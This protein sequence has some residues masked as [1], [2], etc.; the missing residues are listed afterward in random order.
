MNRAGSRP[1]ELL[2]PVASL[3]ALGAAL[4]AELGA[5][6]AALAMRRAGYAAGEALGG[7]LSA[8]IAGRGADGA[9]A[10]DQ[11]GD[12]PSDVFWRRLADF[13]SGRNWGRLRFRQ[14]HEGLGVLEAEKWFEADASGDA[15]RPSCHFTTGMLAN[16]LGQVSGAEIA[17]L[18][19]TCRS[20]GAEQCSFLFGAPPTLQAVYGDLTAGRDL[21]QALLELV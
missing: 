21:Q 13:F 3:K 15:G 7:A 16:L 1:P 2:L 6:G 12:L 19:V 20:Q 5:D 10:D 8:A 17:V 11:L 4:G 9:E 14:L 18:E